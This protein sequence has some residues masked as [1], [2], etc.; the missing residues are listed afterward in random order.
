MT[1]AELLAAGAA[2]AATP[3]IALG[4][5][6]VKIGVNGNEGMAQAFYADDQGYFKARG[7]DDAITILRNGAA[8]TAAVAGGDL[9]VGAS[10]IISLAQAKARGVPISLLAGGAIYDAAANETEKFVVLASGPIHTARD[11][12]GKVIGTP[13][14]SS[15]AALATYAWLDKNGGDSST[16]QFIE[17]TQATMGIALQQGR[18]AA[19]TMEDPDLNAP[20]VALR[21]LGPAYSAVAKSYIVTAWFAGNAWLAANPPAAHAV[22]DALVQGGRWAMANRVT[23]AGAFEKYSKKKLPE[24]RE[25]FA[26]ALTPAL[27]QPVFDAAAKY[28]LLPARVSAADFIWKGR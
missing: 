9:D 5:T 10:N 3:G 19:A 26:P 11:L 25:Y 8:I 7:V 6:Q 17:V 18:I 15:T 20:G 1:R 28:K 27:L 16:V 14:L 21:E 23:A 24:I 13:S 12:T 4:A 22:A 2:F